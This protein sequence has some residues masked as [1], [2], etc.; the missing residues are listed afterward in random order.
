MFRTLTKYFSWRS[1]VLA[2]L[3]VCVFAIRANA[4]APLP[5]PTA[6]QPATQQ[7]HLKYYDERTGKSA[8]ELVKFALE[9]NPE[10]AAMRNEAEA[11]EALIRQARLRP[12]PSLEVSGER[13]IGGMGDYSMMVEGGIPLELGGRRSA[14]IR[15]AEHELEIR[16]LAL[17]ERERQLASEVRSKYAETIAAI[18]KLKFTEDI[19]VMAEQNLSLVTAQVDEGRR[20]PL[21]QSMETVELNRMRAMREAGEGTVEIRML[22]LRNLVGLEPLDPLTLRGDLDTLKLSFPPQAG[23]EQMALQLRPDLKGAIAVEQL[24]AARVEQARSEGRIDADVMLGYQRMKSGFP[25]MGIE[26]ETGA[27]LPIEQTMNF[28]TFGVRFN[29]PV[30][31]RN[32]GMVEAARFEQQA[33]ASRRAFGELAV[34]REVA[35]AYARYNRAV[36]AMEIFRV[37]VRDR[38]AANADVV[39]QTY[40][41]GS[42]TLLDYIAEHHRYIEAENG[43][44]DAQLEAYLAMVEILKAVNSPE[45]K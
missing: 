14:R 18:F 24:S 5:Q 34:K 12:N 41:L 20:P 33:A 30:R 11:G 35:A 8:D 29:L 4:Q 38:A 26:M 39:R 22:E 17:A 21:E 6:D 1:F 7:S 23:A 19:L 44:I 42:K 15:V 13:Q 36:R 40:E 10:I 27:M 28:F 31:N 43:Y 25:L 2:A 45:L 32:Q 9:N 37:G 3:A 16:Q